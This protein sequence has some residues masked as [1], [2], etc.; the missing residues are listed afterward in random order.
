M[1][2]RKACI[3][4]SL[5]EHRQKKPFFSSKSTLLRHINQNQELHT[6]QWK[7][8]SSSYATIIPQSSWRY[9]QTQVDQLGGDGHYL[10]PTQHQTRCQ[11]M[12]IKQCATHSQ[13]DG[14]SLDRISI[15]GMSIW[16]AIWIW[17]RWGIFPKRQGIC[18]SCGHSMTLPS[19]EF[20]KTYQHLLGG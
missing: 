16:Y 18:K 8:S 3:I 17:T 9:L 4:S 7:N 14:A 1:G 19:G 20:S 13:I 5:G 11:T 15:L 6:Y 12:H 10:L 2:P